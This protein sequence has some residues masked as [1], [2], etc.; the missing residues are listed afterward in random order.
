MNYPKHNP[1]TT[2]PLIAALLVLAAIIPTFSSAQDRYLRLTNQDWTRIEQKIEEIST[3]DADAV[4]GVRDQISR[5]WL[6]YQKVEDQNSD[7]AKASFAKG[8][9]LEA[10]LDAKLK[11]KPAPTKPPTTSDSGNP[12]PAAAVG[13]EMTPNEMI[14]QVNLLMSKVVINKADDVATLQRPYTADRVQ[15]WIVGIKALTDNSE[16][17]IQFLADVDTALD[18]SKREPVFKSYRRWFETV[19]PRKIGEGMKRTFEDMKRQATWGAD[20]VVLENN[21][22]NDAYVANCRKQIA[23]GQEAVRALKTSM[24]AF[25]GEQAP[26]EQLNELETKLAAL[27]EQVEGGAEAKLKNARVPEAINDRQL[28]KIAEEA[29]AKAKVQHKGLVVVKEKKTVQKLAW[30]SGAWHPVDYDRF[31]VAAVV[32][33][34]DDHWIKHFSLNFYRQREPGLTTDK[35]QVWPWQETYNYRI[36]PENIDL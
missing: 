15:E 26:L 33:N 12:E 22:N 13:A 3:H 25:A 32:K 16:E 28:Q 11:P 29:L 7:E 18:L 1:P 14:D 6:K 21:L 19:L 10:A 36:L 8:K 24:V 30:D 27:S 17:N 5:A 20:M 9:E 31:A 4:Q 23:T 34:G 2:A 35:W